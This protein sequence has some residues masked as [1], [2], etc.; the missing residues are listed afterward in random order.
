MPQS[1]LSWRQE[2][3][4]L[5]L[6]LYRR[7]RYDQLRSIYRDHRTSDESDELYIL[8]FIPGWK[9]FSKEAPP[10]T[11]RDLY[12]TWTSDTPNA[13]KAKLK[14]A[15]KRERAQRCVVSTTSDVLPL[16]KGFTISRNKFFTLVDTIS[17]A[18][19]V[20]GYLMPGQAKSIICREL[21]IS[22]PSPPNAAAT[23]I[24]RTLR[25]ESTTSSAAGHVSAPVVALRS[26]GSSDLEVKP[27]PGDSGWE[28]TNWKPYS[29][30][31]GEK[32]LAASVSPYGYDSADQSQEGSLSPPLLD[33]SS[34][35]ANRSNEDS[36][37]VSGTLSPRQELQSRGRRPPRTLAILPTHPRPSG[38]S[39]SASSSE[40]GETIVSDL[41]PHMPDKDPSYPLR[42]LRRDPDKQVPVPR[43]AHGLDR[44]LFQPAVHW[45]QDPN[46]GVYNFPPQLQH[47]PSVKSFAFEKV[48]RFIRSSQDPELWTMAVRNRRKFTGSTS[49]LTFIMTHL[50]CLMS[51]CRNVD[52][53]PMS[54]DY[55]NMS[56]KFTSGMRAPGTVNIKHNAGV[57]ALDSSS[58]PDDD[59]GAS[60]RNV[61]SWMGT[62]LEKYLTLPS[63][64]FNTLLRSTSSHSQKSLDK[65]PQEEAYQYSKSKKFVMRS[66]LDCVDSRLPGTGVFDIKTRAAVAIR[67]DRLNYERAS[68]YQIRTLH[69]LFESFEREHYDLIRSA[70][71]KYNFQARIGHMDGIFIAYHNTA[72]IFG[73]QYLSLSEMDERLFGS[74]LAGDRVF[75]KCVELLEQLA[76]TVVSIWPGK[77]VKCTFEST[78]TCMRL[79]V[80]PDGFPAQQNTPITELTLKIENWINGELI[81]GTPVL[82]NPEDKWSIQYKI[83]KA[84]NATDESVT[85]RYESARRKQHAVS[86]MVVPEGVSHDSHEEILKMWEDIDFGGPALPATK[87]TFKTEEDVE[88]FKE[89]F[90][91]PYPLVLE[92]RRLALKGRLEASNNQADV[93]DTEVEDAEMLTQ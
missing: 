27:F 68:G 56:T 88:R 28:P 63:D 61:L 72:K 7:H 5:S 50:Y 66:Q 90:G 58:G 49:S 19:G 76:E 33:L 82:D 62:M 75:G 35:K 77:D 39:R 64:A 55:A 1:A 20:K 24:P 91:R 69:G 65:V 12:N 86:K 85:A 46:S 3:T 9:E 15:L 32:T 36:N 51:R 11:L 59:V 44:V 42:R 60:D 45:V 67:H 80:T 6:F 37:P 48:S 34:S 17:S 23:T 22:D 43:L 4:I 40:D 73:F 54:L 81:Q 41:I 38:I 26:E 21:G 13:L 16:L 52:I 31:D 87:P 84:T 18:Q 10:F 29:L 70:M 89:M 57:Y 2:S 25:E 71:I 83:S 92:T 14:L 47:I 93:V 8:S 53:S 74:R 79:W 78:S 30:N